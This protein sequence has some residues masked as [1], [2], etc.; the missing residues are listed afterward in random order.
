VLVGAGA[1][2][3]TETVATGH[4]ALKLALQ[5]YNRTLQL[6][7]YSTV[8][9]VV[10]RFDFIQSCEY[11]ANSRCHQYILLHINVVI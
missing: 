7:T 3:S 1:L 10:N 11:T 8:D 4:A 2:F 6:T 9:D 5:P